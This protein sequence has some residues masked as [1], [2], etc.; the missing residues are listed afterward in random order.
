MFMQIIT[1]TPIWVFV[2]FTALMVL[3]LIQSRPRTASIQRVMA[4]PLAMVGFSLFGVV[5]GF[6]AS[7]SGLFTYAAMAVIS[8]MLVLQM[9]DSVGTR[10]N[11]ATRQFHIA[12]SW[13]PMMLILGIFVTKYTVG[14]SLGIQPAL[15][16][17][18]I[19]ILP[20]CALYG[21]FSGLLLARCARLW[22][23]A[24]NAVQHVA[25]SAA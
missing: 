13:A 5:S 19:F 1:R 22:Q 3:G 20:V 4:F 9:R 24:R 2:L 23:M 7:Y 21:A 10:Y 17:K 25:A 8:T 16:D 18:S 12:G 15:A 14:V 6:R 11:A